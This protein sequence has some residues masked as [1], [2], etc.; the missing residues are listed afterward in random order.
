MKGLTVVMRIF[1]DFIKSFFFVLQTIKDLASSMEK[2]KSELQKENEEIEK[3]DK[4]SA[5]TLSEG[6]SVRLQLVLQSFPSIH[7]DV[8]RLEACT[9]VLFAV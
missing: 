3:Y 6:V 2:L 1:D 4:E 8:F 7:L 5:S 9:L